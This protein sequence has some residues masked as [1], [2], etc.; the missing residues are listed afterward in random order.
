MA[1]QINNDATCKLA[2]KIDVL[3][4]QTK[5]CYKIVTKFRT[6]FFASIFQI[7]TAKSFQK[8]FLIHVMHFDMQ[9]SM[10]IQLICKMSAQML[11]RL[12]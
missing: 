8:I 12:V 3:F 2:D 4:S 9:K 10:T 5:Q 6:F 11:Y 7:L 1:V